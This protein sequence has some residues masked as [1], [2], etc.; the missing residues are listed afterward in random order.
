M[1]S[2]RI[3]FSTRANVS[4]GV[5]NDQRTRCASVFLHVPYEGHPRYLI[6]LTRLSG[7]PTARRLTYPTRNDGWSHTFSPCEILDACFTLIHRSSHATTDTLSIHQPANIHKMTNGTT[8]GTHP[9]LTAATSSST[10][11]APT[12]NSGL[13]MPNVQDPSQI[14]S[15]QLPHSENVA[16]AT[17]V[18]AS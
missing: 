2:C 4:R 7:S 16:I 11:S 18:P 10:P 5:R 8:N 14:K 12:P 9:G 17:S 6:L 1:L 15:P 13:Y 3:T